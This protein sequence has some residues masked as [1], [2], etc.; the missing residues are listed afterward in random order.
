MKETF[1]SIIVPVYNTEKYINETLNSVL[2]QNYSN[3]EI[4]CVNDGS[5]D[6]SLKILNQ[7]SN[8]DSRVKVIDIKNGGP[9]N[10][11]NVGLQNAQGDYI[12]FLDS[13]D[14]MEQ[15]ALE[16]INKQIIKNHQPNLLVFSATVFNT[17]NIPDWV[18]DSI[19]AYNHVKSD[20]ACYSSLFEE[21]T[22]TPFLWNKAYKNSFLKDNNISFNTTITIGE[23][24]SFLFRVF[25]HAG[26]VVFN[27]DKIYKYRWQRPNSLM[28][29]FKN[30][31]F[32]TTKNHIK[33]VEDVFRNLY[34]NKT[35]DQST[36]SLMQWA[37]ALLY[38][39]HL[40]DLKKEQAL[41]TS[42]K[43]MNIFALYNGSI[44]LER[45]CNVSSWHPEN[46]KA[47]TAIKFINTCNTSYDI[48]IV[49]TE[50]A[51]FKIENLKE[52]L[53]NQKDGL[54]YRF[55]VICFSV[56]FY[57][58]FKSLNLQNSVA[59][60]L[61]NQTF[62]DAKNLVIKHTTSKHI[63]FLNQKD[64]LNTK[65]DLQT[66]IQTL[67]KNS[68][69]SC[70]ILNKQ[71]PEKAINYNDL[72]NF[73]DLN[74]TILKN[75]CISEEISF[76]KAGPLSDVQFLTE[77]LMNKKVLVSNKSIYSST[78]DEYF[79]YLTHENHYSLNDLCYSLGKISMIA[80]KNNLTKL[81]DLV[82]TMVLELN[83][84]DGCK[85]TDNFISINNL[86][87][88]Y[89]LVE[90][91]AQENPEFVSHKNF[92]DNLISKLEKFDLALEDEILEK[93]NLVKEFF[94]KKMIQTINS[95]KR[96]KI[97]QWWRN[98]K[99]GK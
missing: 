99:N 86:I 18:T 78:F 94:D 83:L 27:S 3:F 30:K 98:R 71:L 88:L 33:L 14:L 54:N 93:N 45:L 2:S 79:S 23:D 44:N 28:S 89:P 1:F 68:S 34:T 60:L 82:W 17:D 91:K 36:N 41:E 75:D 13:D 59:V 37:V 20:K 7:L 55:V 19:T 63:L 70:L 81:I 4:V 24:Q 77:I 6:D 9:A 90:F 58:Y 80:L 56:G 74:S 32:D 8:T 67:D 73:V 51:N 46:I 85:N 29:S 10:A 25:T 38:N 84:I 50:N 26:K 11:R 64:L 66:E 76:D 42:R 22:A 21:P 47:F 39:S 97:Y 48:D 16:K 95:L 49:C 43:I 62:S 40:K 61:N 65:I 57:N 53:K 69:C 5:T 96:L 12:L 35:L 31:L 52:F 72:P 87:Y 15:N 92:L